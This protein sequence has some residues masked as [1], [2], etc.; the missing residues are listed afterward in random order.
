VPG[1]ST[2]SFQVRLQHNGEAELACH[3][4]AL[5]AAPFSE[6]IARPVDQPKPK[7]AGA[8]IDRDISSLF[9]FHPVRMPSRASATSYHADPAGEKFACSVRRSLCS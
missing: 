8:P 1:R 9:H 7:A 2:S 4:H 5:V 3:H 6:D